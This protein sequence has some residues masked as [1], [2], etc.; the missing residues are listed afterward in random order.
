MFLIIGWLIIIRSVYNSFFRHRA[1]KKNIF[2]FPFAVVREQIFISVGTRR[3]AWIHRFV[4][5]IVL[6]RWCLHRAI[7]YD[8]NCNSRNN[9]IRCKIGAT[10]NRREFPVTLLRIFTGEGEGRGCIV[11]RSY[12]LSN[13]TRFE[14]KRKH[15]YRCNTGG[16][17]ARY[18]CIDVR[19]RDRI[20]RW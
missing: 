1:I 19:C 6:W 3:E 13:F 15:C 20:F 18:M 11:S 8:F 9:S 7:D 10:V 12:T 17:G 14:H 2:C 5:E 16:K 4:R